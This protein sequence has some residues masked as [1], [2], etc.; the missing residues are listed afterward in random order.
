MNSII[1]SKEGHHWIYYKK[2][3]I[4]VED[5]SKNI[6][7]G[8]LELNDL[9]S[10]YRD[11]LYVRWVSSFDNNEEGD[12]WYVLR[13]EPYDI[14][15]LPSKTRNQIRKCLKT[16]EVKR[17][18]GEQLVAWG[19]YDVYMDEMNRYRERGL[20]ATTVLSE[21]DYAAWMKSEVQD[22]WAVINEEKV[23]A[24]AL[25]RRVGKCINLVTWKA[26]FTHYKLLYPIYGMLYVIVNEYMASGEI[27]YVYDGGR[28]M[29]EHSNVQEFLLTKMGFRKAN[30]KLNAYFR[31]W[32]RPLLAIMSPFETKITNNKIKSL[33]RL[34]KWSR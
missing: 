25:C 7:I 3:F 34:Y 22:I 14:S 13:S 26:D 12:Y 16:C 31:W 1:L 4:S 2:G 8:K 11:S 18:S 19:G 5:P 28:S 21:D 9:L 20:L 17:V 29:T 33:V 27:S 24:Y 10:K 6:S 23:I 15:T 32:L 30:V